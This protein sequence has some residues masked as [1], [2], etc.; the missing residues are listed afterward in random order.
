MK[1]A[2][3]PFLLPPLGAEPGSK[4]KVLRW[5]AQPGSRVSQGAEIVEVEADK[6]AFGVQSPCAGVLS[7]I[8]V[9]PGE[10]VA[11][12]ALLGLIEEAQ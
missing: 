3:I 1:S 12:G 4:A 8:Q 2:E 11:E 10:E 9:R 5:L 6:C 7:R